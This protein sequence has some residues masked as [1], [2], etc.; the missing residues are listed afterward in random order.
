MKEIL[1]YRNHDIYAF[2][3]NTSKSM[4]SGYGKVLYI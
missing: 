1:L 2:I 3:N 4:D